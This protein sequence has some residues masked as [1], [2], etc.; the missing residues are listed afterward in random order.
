METHPG[1]SLMGDS[2]R[3]GQEPHP[4]F[5]GTRSRGGSFKQPHAAACAREEPEGS[6]RLESGAR[7]ENFVL[8]FVLNL[9]GPG[10]EHK[11]LDGSP[12]TLSALR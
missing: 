3:D 6:R 12:S 4:S 1:G 11:A 10:V 5:R 7:S 9:V 8:N 2:S